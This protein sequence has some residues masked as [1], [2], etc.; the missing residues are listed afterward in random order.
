MGNLSV[1]RGL[2][3]RRR[4]FM[5]L[6][7]ALLVIA[8]VGIITVNV[9][10]G[11][12]V[13][14]V[15]ARP[16]GS[17][18]VKSLFINGGRSF[19]VKSGQNKSWAVLPGATVTLTATDIAPGLS[20][21]G[22]DGPL[23]GKPYNPANI[24]VDWD[25]SIA[26]YFDATGAPNVIYLTL[27]S[28]KISPYDKDS[29]AITFKVENDG[30]PYTIMTNIYGV[31][32]YLDEAPLNNLNWSSFT[33]DPGHIHELNST[34]PL[35]WLTDGPHSFFAVAKAVFHIPNPEQ[36]T[37]PPPGDPCDGSGVSNMVYFT[38]DAAPP[39]V[40]FPS[41]E[42]FPLTPIIVITIT[43]VVIV[44]VVYLRKRVDRQ[45]HRSLPSS[46]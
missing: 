44:S 11:G 20:F 39:S 12:A 22:W 17:V 31:T 41:P 8:I 21:K 16:G 14:A 13:L 27:E 10:A 34:L 7:S 15:T 25:K 4:V 43:V 5:L 19:T 46:C 23:N 37:L 38:V 42:S 35:S 9:V 45:K 40:S 33:S 29:L 28:P 1:Q 3:M 24:T 26:A 18:V 32:L 36:Y 30:A 6:I 2:Q